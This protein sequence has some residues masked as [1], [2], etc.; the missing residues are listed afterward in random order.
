MAGGDDQEST[1]TSPGDRRAGRARVRQIALVHSAEGTTTRVTLTSNTPIAVG[2]EPGPGGLAIGDR[3][4][5][6]RHAVF[7]PDG[8]GWRV[9]DL[10]SRNGIVVDGVP[11][12]SAPVHHGSVV[13]IGGAVLVFVDQELGRSPL[14]APET[15][16]LRGASPIM[17]LVRGE[18]AQ[19][20]RRPLPVVIGGESGAGK[21]RVAREIHRLS[22]RSGAMIAVNCAAIAPELAESELF[23]HVAGAF[24]GATARRDGLF[25]AAD[26][27]TLFLDEVGELPLA[28]Q[29]KLLRALAD[30]E[31]RAVGASEVR[32]VDVRVIAASLRDLGAA[33]EQGEFRGDLHARL[34][35]WQLTVP[36]LRARRDDILR[37]AT[38]WLG[39]HHPGMTLSPAAAEALCLF[40]WPYNVR[41][42]EQVLGVSAVRAES[43]GVIAVDHMPSNVAEPLLSRLG[44]TLPPVDAA[45][46]ILDVDPTQPN[47]SAQDLE[48][49]LRHF[50]GSV[51]EVAVFYNRDRR[52][53]Y[54][55]LKRH[56]IDPDLFRATPP[57][58]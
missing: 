28:L 33:V 9:T 7:E 29:P 54:R 10:G 51:A 24:T 13:R 36:P 45:A 20:A 46:L 22:G 16:L 52:Q 40:S 32:H 18:L 15:D 53:V 31:V 42:L 35:G 38:A 41:Q 43:A 30:G 21:E 39:E 19:V 58:R 49:A 23:G 8:A 37:L 50:A 4:I 47:P 3:E 57:P 34:A 14:L 26:K 2:R 5:S 44:V 1:T 6:R 17:Q 56:G 55:W 11:T 48:K 25:V 12:A 27:G